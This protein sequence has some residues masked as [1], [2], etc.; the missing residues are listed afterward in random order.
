MVGGMLGMVLTNG[1]RCGGLR[2]SR[3]GGLRISNKLIRGVCI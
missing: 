1:D 3:C 2:I